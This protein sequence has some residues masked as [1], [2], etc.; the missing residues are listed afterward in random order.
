V[1]TSRLVAAVLVGLAALVEPASHTEVGSIRGQVI[2]VQP[3]QTAGRPA[4]SDLTM[5]RHEPVDRRRAVVYLD[6]A[7]RQAFDELRP[8]RA[9]MDQRGQQ[10]VPRVLA[11]IVGTTVDFPNSDTTFHNAFSLAPVRTFDL[12]RYRPGRTKSVK[13]DRAGIV[14]VSCDIHSHMSAYIL[15]FNH[16]FFAVTDEDG[17]FAISGVPPSTY[18]VSVWSELGRPASRRVTVVDGD[19]VE[20]NFQVGRGGS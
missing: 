7:P 3:A 17:R 5:S 9:K 14:P 13:F 8:G 4:V 6:A 2:V 10:F 19:V 11:I 15:V 12:G 1:E 20:A 18:T 16:P